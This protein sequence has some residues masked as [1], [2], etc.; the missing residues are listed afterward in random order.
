MQEAAAKGA[1]GKTEVQ[2]VPPAQTGA[3]LHGPRA[4]SAAGRAETLQMQA[5]RPIFKSPA[6]NP[7]KCKPLQR[8]ELKSREKQVVTSARVNLKCKTIVVFA[9]S[10]PI[11]ACL[12]QH[13]QVSRGEG[14]GTPS[15]RCRQGARHI[16]GPYF[17]D[18]SEGLGRCQEKQNPLDFPKRKEESWCPTASPGASTGALRAVWCGLGFSSPRAPLFTKLGCDDSFSCCPDQLSSCLKIVLA[19]LSHRKDPECCYSFIQT[20][21]QA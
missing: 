20:Q 3:A 4:N 14:S 9:G 7:E 19:P 6:A 5:F 18:V 12:H 2:P 21:T 8:H 10:S 11:P 16:S 1:F 15:H 13:L 17:C